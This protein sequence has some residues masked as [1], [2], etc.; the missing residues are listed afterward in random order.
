MEDYETT[1]FAVRCERAKPDT[2]PEVRTD[3]SRA[4]VLVA[5]DCALTAKAYYLWGLAQ[6]AT[7]LDDK[8]TLSSKQTQWDE[9]VRR[10]CGSTGCLQSVFQHRIQW[11][12]NFIQDNSDPL[13][14]QASGTRDA[15]ACSEDRTDYFHLKFAVK[16]HTVSGELDGSGL[17]G[18]RVFDGDEF[19]GA[20][21]GNL[22]FVAFEAGFRDEHQP[23]QALIVSRHGHLYWQ[24]LTRIEV[25]EYVWRSADLI[26][27]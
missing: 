16:D 26:A 14:Q 21:S 25:E 23:G 22:A 4:D 5:N 2:R 15:P 6:V 12:T 13:P 7:V 9:T 24:V 10:H 18:N 17:C 8:K 27:D 11:L 1:S 19:R 3:P 20:Q